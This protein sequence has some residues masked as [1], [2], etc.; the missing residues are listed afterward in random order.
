MLNRIKQLFRCKKQEP[1]GYALLRRDRPSGTKYWATFGPNGEEK[2]DLSQMQP[3]VLP[4][5][6]I[7]LG[8]RVEIYIGEGKD[9]RSK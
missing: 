4:V 2:S 8:T 9:D 7:P 3:L 1:D 6:K 5:E